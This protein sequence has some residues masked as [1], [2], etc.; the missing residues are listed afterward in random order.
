MKA[1]LCQTPVVAS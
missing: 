1:A